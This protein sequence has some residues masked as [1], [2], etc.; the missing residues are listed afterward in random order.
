MGKLFDLTGAEISTEAPQAESRVATP[1]APQLPRS[2]PQDL[3]SFL[4][5]LQEG[6]PEAFASQDPL[7]HVCEALALKIADTLL[8]E[9]YGFIAMGYVPGPV[10]TGNQAFDSFFL[11]RVPRISLSTLQLVR[12][13]LSEGRMTTLI[14]QAYEDGT[15]SFWTGLLKKSTQA[16]WAPFMIENEGGVTP[17]TVDT[18][19]VTRIATPQM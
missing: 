9:K 8:E 10:H 12:G 7:T 13:E 14:A 19:R 18:W 17:C 11:E 5:T 1:T 4:H 6:Q 2:K 3:T 16:L 15:M